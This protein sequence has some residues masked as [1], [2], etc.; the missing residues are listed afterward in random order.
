MQYHWLQN[1][2][3]AMELELQEICLLAQLAERLPTA[4]M[5][6]QIIEKIAEEAIEANTWNCIYACFD[7][8]HV[9]G[10]GCYNQEST[11]EKK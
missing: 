11:Q 1:V 5:R 10:H 4:N 9:P 2:K 3:K 6:M 8:S 7:S